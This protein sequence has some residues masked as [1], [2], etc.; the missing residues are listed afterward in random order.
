M[1]K[2]IATTSLVLSRRNFLAGIGSTAVLVSS[3]TFPRSDPATNSMV[4]KV[5]Q[6]VQAKRNLIA[7][8]IQIIDTDP[9]VRSSLQTVIDQNLLH[10]DA[11]SQYLPAIA[12]PSTTP[13]T[14]QDVGLSGLSTRC[15][16]ISSENLR[17]ACELPDAELS[18]VLALIAG[19][20]IQHHVLLT[21]LIA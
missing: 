2:F 7:D 13:M 14:S 8:A 4:N 12:S 6:I 5:E 9:S 15:A 20:E 10:I 17:T 19:S 18:R 1:D 3:C 21:G 11:L 16:L